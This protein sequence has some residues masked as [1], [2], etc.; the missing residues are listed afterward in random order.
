MLYASATIIAT[1]DRGGGVGVGGGVGT[2]T[3]IDALSEE[4]PPAPGQVTM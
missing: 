4:E 2:F 1:G 3:N